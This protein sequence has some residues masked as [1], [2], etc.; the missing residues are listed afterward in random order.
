MGVAKSVEISGFAVSRYILKRDVGA[1]LLVVV[2]RTRVVI[3]ILRLRTDDA[4]ESQNCKMPNSLHTDMSMGVLP[5]VSGTEKEKIMMKASPSLSLKY[6]P[7]SYCI[8]STILRHFAYYFLSE[9]ATRSLIIL[10]Q[11]RKQYKLP[12]RRLSQFL[13]NWQKECCAVGMSSPYLRLTDAR[14]R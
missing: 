5:F 7:G 10:I 13:A 1:A 11:H 2:I 14:P 6:K 8:Y 12:V 9:N 3:P 4:E